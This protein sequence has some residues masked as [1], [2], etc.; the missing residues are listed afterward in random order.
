MPAQ[1]TI[2]VP[3]GIGDSIWLFQKLIN[4]GEKF[5]FKLPDSKPQRGKQIFELLPQLSETCEYGVFKFR[6]VRRDNIQSRKKKWGDILDKNI[7]LTANEYLEAGNRIEGFFPDLKTSF[8]LDYKT[9]EYTKEAKEMLSGF[10]YIGI[11][12]SCYSTSRSWGFWNPEKW[13]RLIRALYAENKDFVFVIIGADFDADLN[14]ELTGLLVKE[15]IP[16][17]EVI[18]RPLGFVVEVMKRLRYFFSFPSGLGIMSTTLE[19]PTTMFYPPAL[20]N[21]MNSWPD[22]ELIS[23]NTYKGCQF[24]EPEA[25]LDWVK[26]QYKL[27][28]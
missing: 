27:L 18:G 14:E 22:P 12:G 9:S 13:M 5:H 26:N 16:F 23:N 1:R 2:R 11:Y 4:S 28:I 8:K 6:D 10:N 7:S 3:P 17:I 15:D 20:R 21:L 19:V 24:C 25:I